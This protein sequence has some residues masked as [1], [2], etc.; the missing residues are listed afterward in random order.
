MWIQIRAVAGKGIDQLRQ[1]GIQVD[2]GILDGECRQLNAAFFAR[3]QQQRPYVTLKWAQSADGKVAGPK[4]QR[5][6]IS[7]AV[8]QRVIH[9]LR[10]RSDAILVGI[11]TALMDDPLLTARHVAAARPL[12]R[13]VLD[14]DLRL[15]LNSQ[16]VQTAG[17]SPVL[18]YCALS[19]LQSKPDAVA[20]LASCGVQVRALPLDAGGQLSLRHLFADLGTQPITHLLVEPGPTLAA[21]FLGQNLCDRLWVIRSPKTIGDATA[22]DALAVPYPPVGSVDLAGDELTEYLNPASPVY[23]MSMPSADLVTLPPSNSRPVDA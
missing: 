4:G 6:W 16:L 17:Q 5:T 19:T 15:P 7:N 11:N 23:F 9:G 20:A 18:V 2:V 3:V 8:S 21:S 13:I 10:A 1:A 22:P 12:L 14:R